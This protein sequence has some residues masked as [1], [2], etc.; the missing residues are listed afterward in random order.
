MP[1]SVRD[2]PTRCHEYLFLLS[3]SKAYYFDA[4]AIREPVTSGPSDVR[5]MLEGRQRIGGKHKTLVDAY[6]SASSATNIGRKRSVG[7][8]RWRNKRSVWTVATTPFRGA[9]FATFP[10]KLIEPCIAAGTRRSDVVLDPFSGT[11][12]TRQVAIDLGRHYVGCE[13]SP[14]YVELERLRQSRD[15]EVIR[16]D[17]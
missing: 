9:H 15:Q 8:G 14:A 12:T 4:A 11:G 17:R 5:K 16:N 3:K 10:R 2:R 13:L 1:E 7:D 6:S